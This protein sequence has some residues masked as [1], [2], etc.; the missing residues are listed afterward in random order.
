MGAKD[1]DRQA[2]SGEVIDHD[3]SD[4][5]DADNHG[6]DCDADKNV[7]EDHLGADDEVGVDDNPFFK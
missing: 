7:Y 4:D 1:I 6:D 3:H 5:C 2:E